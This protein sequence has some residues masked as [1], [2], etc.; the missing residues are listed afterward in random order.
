MS[1]LFINLSLSPDYERIKGPL[2][3]I[4]EREQVLGTLILAGEGINGTIAGP[5]SG[6]RAVL[7]HI[8]SDD[9]LADLKHKESYSEE[10]NPF[11]RIKIHLKKEIVTMGVPGIDPLKTVGTYVKPKAWNELISDPDVILID[12]R[13]IYETAIGT[14]SGAVDPRT[15]NFRD[16]PAWVDEHKAQLSKKPKIAMFCTGGIRCEKATSLML[17]NGYDEVFHLEGGILKY[18]EEVP[19]DQSMWEGQCFVFDERVSVG[20]GLVPGSYDLCHACRHPIDAEDKAS[21][22]YE[23]GV[24]CPHCHLDTTPEQKARFAERQK[25]IRLASERGEQHFRSNTG[26]DRKQS[27]KES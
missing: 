23:L 19:T 14:F 12:T 2:L 20:H 4:C 5:H 6:V 17:E 25:Q 11:H 18:L 22:F 16:F 7:D 10:T 3:A 13:N 1:Q 8:R 15:V 27:Q 24:S 9:R 26:F 21:E